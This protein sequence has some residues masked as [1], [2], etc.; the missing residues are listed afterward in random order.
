MKHCKM[1]NILSNWSDQ[2]YMHCYNS[3]TP[4]IYSLFLSSTFAH[5][6][7]QHVFDLFCPSRDNPHAHHRHALSDLELVLRHLTNSPFT[8]R[9]S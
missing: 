2:H 6:L 4:C 3:E 9:S 8:T 7:T 5:Q 1:K